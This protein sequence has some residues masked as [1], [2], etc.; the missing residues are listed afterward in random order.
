MA[1]VVALIKKNPVIAVLGGLVAIGVGGVVASYVSPQVKPYIVPG[2]L[3]V[4][5]IFMTTSV[6]KKDKEIR[7]LGVLLA[8]GGIG[9]GLYNAVRSQL[10]STPKGG[11]PS[12]DRPCVPGTDP[13]RCVRA[14][15]PRRLLAGYAYCGDD[16]IG[17]TICL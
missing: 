15:D 11:E 1:K 5:G 6:D 16:L 7:A 13:Q 8:A 12:K 17:K 4:G 9:L 14:G 2:G 3:V 10:M